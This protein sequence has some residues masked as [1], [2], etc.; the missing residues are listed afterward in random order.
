MKPQ[1]PDN[2]RTKD[3]QDS[4]EDRRKTTDYADNR[5]FYQKYWLD[6]TGMPRCPLCGDGLADTQDTRMNSRIR[7][8]T[9]PPDR[10]MPV[11]VAFVDNPFPNPRLPC[12]TSVVSFRHLGFS[13]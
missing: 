6:P 4:Q 8:S 5:R 9:N 3:A 12:D 10:Q 7:V 2:W 11:S 1:I 13:G